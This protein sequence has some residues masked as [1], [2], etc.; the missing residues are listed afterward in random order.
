MMAVFNPDFYGE[1]LKSQVPGASSEFATSLSVTDTTLVVGDPGMRLNGFGTPGAVHVFYREGERW[2]YHSSVFRPNLQ[3]GARFGQAVAV[4]NRT[5]SQS[6]MIVGEPGYDAPNPQPSLPD[7]SNV[8]RASVFCDD[9][10]GVWHLSRSAVPVSENEGLGASVD[11]DFVGED[12]FAVAGAPNSDNGIGRVWMLSNRANSSVRNNPTPNAGDRFGE[13]VSINGNSIAVG[14]P[15]E[16]TTATDAG[17]A[18]IYDAALSNGIYVW[19]LAF[20]IVGNR[21]GGTAA[22][23]GDRAGTSVLYRGN[24]LAV[25]VPFD[26]RGLVDD[27]SVMVFQRGATGIVQQTLLGAAFSTQLGLQLTGASDFVITSNGNGATAFSRT[28]STWT[29]VANRFLAYTAVSRSSDFIVDR[30]TSVGGTGRYG[31]SNTATLFDY[32]DS[33]EF[34][35]SFAENGARHIAAGPR[36]GDTRS[37]ESDFSGLL[38]NS[39]DGVTFDKLIAGS[40]SNVMTVLVKDANQGAVLDAWMSQGGIVRRI[41]SGVRVENGLNRIV[42]AIEGDYIGNTD[43]RVRLSSAGVQNDRGAAEDGEVEDYVVPVYGT[44]TVG[45]TNLQDNIQVRRAGPSLNLLEVVD[46]DTTTSLLSVP[47]NFIDS[48][49]I[50]G[51]TSKPSR[52][53]VDAL[54]LRELR[55]LGTSSSDELIVSGPP[56]SPLP[57]ATAR[58]LSKGQGMGDANVEVQYSDGS[59]SIVSFSSIETLRLHSMLQVSIDGRLSVATG[60]VLETP[61]PTALNLSELTVLSGGTIISTNGFALGAGE[62][63]FGTGTMQGRIQADV[64]ALI[65]ATGNL[66]LGDSSH[67]AGY[68]SRG[69]LAI[70]N[71]NVT[72]LDARQSVL[73]SFTTISGGTL[74]AGTGALLDFGHIL[75]GFG[76]I[77][78]P[79]N[80]NVP[81]L[82]NG[83]IIGS[84][85]TNR[86][87]LPGYV[88]GVGSLSNVNLTGTYSPGLSPAAVSVGNLTYGTGSTTVMEL[89]GTTAG[90]QHDQV[91][92]NGIAT[93][94]GTL[95]IR[96]IDGFTP[97]IGNS[98]TLMT[99]SDGLTGQFSQV[100]L[101]PAPAGSKWDLIYSTHQLT[102]VL[103]DLITLTGSVINGAVTNLNRS[104]IG[105]MRFDFDQPVTV[106]SAGSLVLRNHTTGA[107]VSANSATLS[108]NGTSSLTWDLSNTAL[109][110]GRYTAE[111]V[112]DQ[113]LNAQGRPLGV[114]H[115]VDFHKRAGDLNGDGAVNFADYSVIG[116]NFNPIAGVRY[117]AGDADGNGAVNFADYAIVGAN[118]AP[119]ALPSLQFDFGDAPESNSLT[120]FPTT[121]ARDGARHLVGSGVYMGSSVDAEPNGSPS[122]NADCDG[123]DEDGVIWHNWIV[124]AIAS[125][126]VRAVTPSVAY[127]NAWID[128]NGDGD[129]D[130]VDESIL[131]DRPVTSGVNNFNISIPTSASSGLRYARVRITAAPG[132]GYKGLAATGEVEDYRVT[133]AA[134]QA[135][136]LSSPYLASQFESSLHWH[137]DL[138]VGLMAILAEEE[139]NRRRK[140]RSMEV[141][142][143]KEF[144]S[145]N[146]TNG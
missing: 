58:Y 91:N 36:L 82:V 129:W 49:T 106:P 86:I 104:G 137:S 138:D 46:L 8:G 60:Q 103:A 56:S 14:A 74:L 30:A 20:S 81:L 145:N 136:Q 53:L 55:I 40:S 57:T 41:A 135:L 119:V 140:S 67:L 92:H 88:K 131:I 3:D 1:G 50:Q 18:Y 68:F 142:H 123:A 87:T 29:E 126:E 44:A 35:T 66:T 7:I 71:R 61:M 114:T 116:A 54:P 52:Y 12:Y 24:T 34:R 6:C 93:L 11:I 117:R 143:S 79:N 78:T 28:G 16:D 21:A 22:N 139:E 95:D 118:F 15:G 144:L 99:A 100:N 43:F 84:S 80:I 96:L 59:R 77:S 128:F 5:A 134:G 108:G 45:L 31:R 27:G 37:I 102:L 69:E 101:P 130:D 89:G 97:S 83:A 9:S 98:F 110:N 13:S 111:L 17:M 133:V 63:L 10:D 125:L 122:V 32:G 64:G 115:V 94:N 62:S 113:Q 23:A 121:L 65:S 105:T 141:E 39:D 85:S 90:S 75:A 109:P 127:I 51:T 48:V 72:L 76:T 4:A 42:F 120:T 25:G 38:D 132:H 19:N 112:S 146:I 124:G 107:L 33:L 26:D 2:E 47:Y 70:A 73:G